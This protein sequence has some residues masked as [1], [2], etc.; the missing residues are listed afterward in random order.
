MRVI[1]P[2]LLLNYIDFCHLFL[3]NTSNHWCIQLTIPL[4]ESY[5]D[6]KMKDVIFRG[7]SFEITEAVIVQYLLEIFQMNPATINTISCMS[8]VIVWGQR[9]INTIYKTY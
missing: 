9:L 6:L 7:C 4:R 2:V 5:N 3:Q 8:R 1:K